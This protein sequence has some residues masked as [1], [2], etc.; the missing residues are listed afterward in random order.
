M[1]KTNLKFGVAI[2]ATAV[3][4]SVSTMFLFQ[5]FAPKQVVVQETPAQV[6]QVNNKALVNTKPISQP[7]TPAMPGD[8]VATANTVMDG[9]VNITTYSGVF[10]ASSGS[11]VVISKDGYII[12]NNHVVEDGT[13]VKI[14][15][16]NNRELDAKIV[17]TDPTTDL[18][19]LKVDSDNL[20]PLKFGNSDNTKVGEWVLAVGNPFNLASTV[21]AGIVSAKGRNIDILAGT[22]F[23]IESFIQTDA[24]VNPGN[25]GGALVNASGELIG[26]NTAI[27]TESGGYE[28]YSFAVPAN[29]VQKVITDL[30][31]YGEVKRAVLGVTIN[32]V[33]DQDARLYDLE[34]V[35]GVKVNGIVAGGS[36]DQAGLEKYDIIL[37]V[38]SQKVKSVASL[39][40]TVAQFR[41]GDEISL[42]YVRD[43]ELYRADNVKLKALEDTDFQRGR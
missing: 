1:S 12:T 19:L 3:V 20:E 11:G 15:F 16:S 9:V 4:T 14:T 23:S 31:D 2:L 43:G 10:R 25:S 42:L 6:L 37:E 39:Q 21:T 28:G 32:N 7:I 5:N 17:G 26:I 36:A 30:R 41:P 40:E 34:E 18:A 22:N 38:N 24:V 35:A 8:F 33:T 29:L 27:M 13:S